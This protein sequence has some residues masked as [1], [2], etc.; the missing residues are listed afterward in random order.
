M[1]FWRRGDNYEDRA[2]S[3]CDINNVEDE[4]HVLLHCSLYQDIHEEIF[5]KCVSLNT[6]FRNF[7]P[8][9]QLCFILSNKD[10]VKDVAR[11]CYRILQR[12][13][14]FSLS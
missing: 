9:D 8:T 6:D 12:R 4:Q 1:P 2:C 3:F 11:A 10:L 14:T 5:E 13:N 7:T